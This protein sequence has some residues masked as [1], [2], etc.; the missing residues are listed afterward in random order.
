MHWSSLNFNFLPSGRLLSFLLEFLCVPLFLDACFHGPFSHFFE[1]IEKVLLNLRHNLL[2]QLHL[3]LLLQ[4]EDRV[5]VLQHERHDQVHPNHDREVPELNEKVSDQVAVVICGLLE[6]VHRDG[7]IVDDHDGKE[8]HNWGEEVVEVVG[9][10]DAWDTVEGR[11]VLDFSAEHDHANDAED[12]VDEEEDAQK[13][14]QLFHHFLHAID[15]YFEGSE[16]V[17][18]SSQQEAS[19]E[20]DHF[21]F[22]RVFFVVFDPTAT[23]Y[24]MVT[25]EAVENELAEG[26]QLKSNGAVTFYKSLC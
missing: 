19:Q 3:P 2:L 1:I 7:P 20:Y 25:D 9:G 15:D 24:G 13:V 21:H 6:L 18:V 5:V 16:L 26:F 12:V 14:L 22:F 23:V 10:V 17:K 11:V 8:R 4:F